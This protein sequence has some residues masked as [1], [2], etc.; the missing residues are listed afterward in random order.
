MKC[1]ECSFKESIEGANEV[2]CTLTGEERLPKSECNCERIRVRRENEARLLAE[3]ESAVAM[4]NKLKEKVTK[5][6]PDLM[7]VYNGLH[8]IR[9]EVNST[10]LEELIQYLEGYL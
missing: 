5:P 6:F 4:L 9:A 7:Y 10:K 2:R 1:R 8:Q 3:K